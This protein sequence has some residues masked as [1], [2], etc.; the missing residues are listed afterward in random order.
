LSPGIREGMRRKS[1]RG[2]RIALISNGC[3]LDDFDRVKNDSQKGL[4]IDLPAGGLICAFTGAHG[5]A[6]GLD[7]VLDAALVLMKKKRFDIQF[8]FIGE[9]VRKLHLKKRTEKEGL[10]NCTFYG[11]L[12]RMELFKILSHIDVGLM[13]LDDVPAFYNGTCPNKLFDYIAAGLPVLTNYPGWIANMI[14]KYGCGKAV[15]P[16]NATA[17]ADAL[18]EM[19]DNPEYRRRMGQNSR[20]LSESRFSRADLFEKFVTFLE[21]VKGKRRPWHKPKRQEKQGAVQ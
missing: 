21:S 7:A 20:S 5:I 11:L 10:R 8:I 12:P 2:K 6:N 19:A 16:G 13:I 3:D 1:A 17:F 14:E 18:I 4:A 15:P 9:G